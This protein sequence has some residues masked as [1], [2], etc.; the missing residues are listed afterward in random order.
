M[1]TFSDLVRGVDNNLQEDRR[2]TISQ[3]GV[4]GQWFN[5]DEKVRTPVTDWT[6]S[7]AADFFEVEFKNLLNGMNK[8]G[9]YVEN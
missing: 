1:P 6:S 3:S 9:N 8:N 7:Q 5:D 2:F 4:A